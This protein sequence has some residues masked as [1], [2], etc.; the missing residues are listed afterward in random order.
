MKKILT[1]ALS[2][3]FIGVFGQAKISDLPATTTLTG[4][5]LFPVVQGGVTKKTTA[6]QIVSLATSSGTNY[7]PYS[8]ANSFTTSNNITAASFISTGQSSLNTL[9]VP[10]TATVN[11]VIYKNG[12]RFLHNFSKSGTTGQ[13]T[14]LGENAG[15]LTLTGSAVSTQG[16]YNVAVGYNSGSGL[17]VGNFNTLL[18]HSAG[19][20]ITSGGFNVCIG[21]SAGILAGT[22]NV[23]IG[24]QAGVYNVNSQNVAI[25]QRALFSSTNTINNVAVGSNCG[26]NNQGNTNIFI[27]SQS[28]NANITGTGNIYIGTGVGTGIKYQSNKLYIDYANRVDSSGTVTKSLI[29]GV[30]AAASANQ[31]LTINATNIIAGRHL[32]TQGASVASVAGAIALGAD[33]NI[34]EITGTNAITLISNSGWKDGSE[35][36]LLFTST[37]TLTDGTATSSTNVGMELAGNTN[38]TATADDSITLT[39]CTVGGVQRWREKCRSVN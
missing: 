2:I 22:G 28:G 11:G 6:A 15:N 21:R 8:G 14:F 24:E 7:V 30:F 20:G 5:E 10:S 32:K 4:V 38:F 18:G 37:A 3:A 23:F 9:Y 12:N 13:N 29:Y 31:S 16:S 25:G 1:L 27:G 19:S 39:L 26:S 34:F 36:T 17:S 33:G 35:V